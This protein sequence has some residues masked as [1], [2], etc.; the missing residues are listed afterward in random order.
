MTSFLLNLVMFEDC[1]NQ[2]S[3]SRPLLGLILLQP[4]YFDE[5]SQRIVMEAA[6]HK[7]ALYAQCFV[8]LMNGVER[9]LSTKNRDRFTQASVPIHDI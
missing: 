6:A 7:Q 2:W 1:K 3:V 4:D 8:N 5:A 9:T